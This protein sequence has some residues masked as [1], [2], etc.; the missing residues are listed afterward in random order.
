MTMTA[1][2]ARRC[3]DRLPIGSGACHTGLRR[4]QGNPSGTLR[5][6]LTGLGR[7]AGFHGIARRLAMGIA[8]SSLVLIFLATP[9]LAVEISSLRPGVYLPADIGCQGIGGAGELYFD[10]K[11]FSGHY[12][13]CRTDPLA[14]RNGYR[15]TCVEAQGAD[16]PKLED[17]DKDPDRTTADATIVARSNRAFDYNNTRYNFCE[18]P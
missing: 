2:G 17:I 8:A 4:G 13:L 14:W 3:P 5:V 6:A 11:N 15:S 7:M 12:Q 18:A 9:S 1:S 10:G 16:Q